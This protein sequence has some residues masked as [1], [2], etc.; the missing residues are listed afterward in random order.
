M[1]L[2]APLFEAGVVWY[3]EDKKFPEEVSRRGYF[4][5]VW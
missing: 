5:S 3:P 4:F 2:V 1:H